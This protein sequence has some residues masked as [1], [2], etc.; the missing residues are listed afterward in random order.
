MVRHPMLAGLGIVI[1]IAAAVFL[2]SQAFDWTNE[3]TDFDGL[4]AVTGGAREQAQEELEATMAERNATP[5]PTATATPVVFGDQF[6]E[7][8]AVEITLVN[9]DNWRFDV[10]L[11]SPYDT[12]ERY[13]DAWRVLDDTGKELGIRVLAHDHASEQPFTR[14]ET[15]QVP[16]RLDMV[17]VEGRDQDNGWSGQRFEVSMP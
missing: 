13:A 16:R 14:S 4:D 17:F 5:E 11:S 2:A 1:F 12:A 6:P 9:N 10:T 3:N 15:I 8:L 7:V